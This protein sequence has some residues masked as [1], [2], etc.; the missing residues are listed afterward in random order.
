[1]KNKTMILKSNDQKSL[2]LLASIKQYKLIQDEIKKLKDNEKI[3]KEIF[4]KYDFEKVIIL[5]EQGDDTIFQ[6]TKYF[7]SRK[8]LNIDKLIE[9]IEAHVCGDLELTDMITHKQQFRD[10]LR[11]IIERCYDE[12]KVE[13]VKFTFK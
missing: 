1:M 7:Q 2:S 11:A 4:K 8:E 3:L 10:D 6:V 9:L 5:D 12:K 13:C